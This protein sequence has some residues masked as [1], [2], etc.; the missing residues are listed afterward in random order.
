MNALHIKK[1]NDA[2]QIPG[3]NE[4]TEIDVREVHSLATDHKGVVHGTCEGERSVTPSSVVEAKPTLELCHT[5]E[6]ADKNKQDKHECEEAQK[7][8]K[9]RRDKSW[10]SEL[11]RE[12]RKMIRKTQDADV[13][14]TFNNK[15]GDGAD[16]K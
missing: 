5:V 12:Y 6:N 8:W 2:I 11:E 3:N 14:I 15:T 10:T 9:G 16:V 13:Y 1:S 7:R 4:R